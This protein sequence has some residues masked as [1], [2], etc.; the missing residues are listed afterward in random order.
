MSFLNSHG[1]EGTPWLLI[2]LWVAFATFIALITI[3]LIIGVF[4]QEPVN[5]P[6]LGLT[7]CSDTKDN[8]N[9]GKID[10]PKD[11]DCLNLFDDSEKRETI[12]HQSNCGNGNCETG[13][14]F[15]NC[16]NDCLC[17]DD[18]CG[19]TESFSTCLLDC[20]CGNQICDYNES[21]T[22]CPSDCT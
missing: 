14:N 9:D 16:P 19:P 18:V 7:E 15:E 6:S 17:G 2:S 12:Q 10:F 8:D 22:D 13:E 11:P 4:Y 20:H 5:N 3:G 21:I 1:Q